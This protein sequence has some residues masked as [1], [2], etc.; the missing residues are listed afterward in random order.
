M[1]ELDFWLQLVPLN[2]EIS[3]LQKKNSYN[4][5]WTFPNHHQPSVCSPSY[6][7]AM[8]SLKLFSFLLPEVCLRYTSPWLSWPQ[9]SARLFLMTYSFLTWGLTFSFTS[10]IFLPLQGLYGEIPVTVPSILRAL[11]QAFCF[12]VLPH[13]CPKSLTL[14]LW[15]SFFGHLSLVS[16][17]K[18]PLTS[19]RN[20]SSA[21]S[22]HKLSQFP[23]TCVFLNIRFHLLSESSLWITSGW[24]LWLK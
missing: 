24:S 12:F 14:H 11:Y 2:L 20:S 19:N 22:Q 4:L 5:C 3:C 10:N 8:Y 15:C 21:H 7:V 17:P 1:R 9:L 23:S 18:P 16:I 6:D 13:S